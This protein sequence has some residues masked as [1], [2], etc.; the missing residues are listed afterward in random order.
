MLASVPWSE[1]VPQ[2]SAGGLVLAV[3]LAGYAAAGAPVLGWLAYRRLARRRPDDPRALSRFSLLTL[4]VQWSWAVVIMVVLI[5]S[6]DLRG[7]HLGLRLPHDL[8]PLAA[9]LVGLLAVLGA[10]WFLDRNRRQKATEPVGGPEPGADSLDVL[11]PR[12]RG[13]RRLALATSV[14]ASVCEELLYRAFL[15]ALGVAVGL[16]LWVAAVLAV[17]LYALAHIYQGWWGLVGPGLFG[18]LFMILYLGTG[19]LLVPVILH[20]LIDLRAL[21]F[22]GRGRRHRSPSA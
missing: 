10:L 3:V 18:A 11:A 19:S 17:L 22:T 13:E 7:E 2:L 6:P 4:A 8:L 15:V 20:L 21:A 16:P 9:A 12:T 5:A 14:T 1:T